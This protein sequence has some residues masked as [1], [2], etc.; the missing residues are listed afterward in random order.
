MNILDHIGHTPLPPYISSKHIGRSTKK[1]RSRYQTVY[2]KNT[3]SVAAPTAGFHFTN[4]LMEQIPNKAFVILHVGLGTFLPVKTDNIEDHKMH[5]EY[6]N[7]S[8]SAKHLVL[9]AK[10]KKQRIIA[11]G[12]TCVRTLES[13]WSK[14]ETSIFIFPGYKFKMVDAMI[15]NFHLPK[16][17]LLMLVSAFAGRELVMKAYSEAIKQKYCFYSFGDAMLII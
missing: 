9:S 3:G 4:E 11:V 14:P 13:D 2:A 8:D 6:F 12:T 5:S 10:E 7:I 1:I 16:S 15:T 17:T